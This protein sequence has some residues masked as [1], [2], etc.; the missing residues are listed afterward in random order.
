ML[1]RRPAV[2]APDEGVPTATIVGV[3][4]PVAGCIVLCISLGVLLVRRSV[5]RSAAAPSAPEVPFDTNI[6]SMTTDSPP[7]SGSPDFPYVSES[8]MFIVCLRLQMCLKETRVSFVSSLH[9]IFIWL[10]LAGSTCMRWPGS[11]LRSCLKKTSSVIPVVFQ[12]KKASSDEPNKGEVAVDGTAWNP[13]DWTV[14]M[15]ID[16]GDMEIE[17]MRP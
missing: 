16:E 6:E 1:R 12:T 14:D 9:G 4:I 7:S 17:K 8:L 3:V 5:T 15:D 2:S 13:A 11:L 10:H